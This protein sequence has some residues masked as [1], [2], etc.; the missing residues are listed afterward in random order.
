M[1][2]VL[3]GSPLVWDVPEAVGIPSGVDS[4][5]FSHRPL[6]CSLLKKGGDGNIL[7]GCLGSA[8]VDNS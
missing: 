6:R 5:H 2:T 1:I 4:N 8:V 7:P 3:P